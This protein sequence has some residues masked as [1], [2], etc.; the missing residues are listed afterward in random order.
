MHH[1][2]LLNLHLNLSSSLAH[3]HTHIENDHYF[4]LTRPFCMNKNLSDE[5]LK[6]YRYAL[7]FVQYLVPFCVIS[8]VYIQMAVRLWGTRAPGNAQD[9]RDITLLKNKKKVGS[10]RFVIRLNLI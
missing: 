3:T 9:S 10:M 7:V 5:Q 6:A 8:F 4:N 1:Y 2:C